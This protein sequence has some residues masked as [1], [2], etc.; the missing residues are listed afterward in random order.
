MENHMMYQLMEKNIYVVQKQKM[1][2]QIQKK[3]LL[4]KNM[5]L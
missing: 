4:K 2:K 5:K 3:L 1:L